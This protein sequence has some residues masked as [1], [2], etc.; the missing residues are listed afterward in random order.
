[1][2][3]ENSIIG[4]CVRYN[5]GNPKCVIFIG[6]L[7]IFSCNIQ[8]YIALINEESDTRGNKII[9]EI[10]KTYFKTLV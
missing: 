7:V 6:I 3:M 9:C 10:F 2:S 4:D 1:M 5:Y 8:N